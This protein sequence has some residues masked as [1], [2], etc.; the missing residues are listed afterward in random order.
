MKLLRLVSKVRK[1]TIGRSYTTSAFAGPGNRAKKEQQ[2]SS[3]QSKEK[4]IKQ[5]ERTREK[6]KDTN[7]LYDEKWQQEIS[8]QGGYCK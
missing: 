6:Q 5:Q 8:K 7:L 3:T 1:P 2:G 4:D